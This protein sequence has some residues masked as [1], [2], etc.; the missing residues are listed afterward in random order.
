MKTNNFRSTLRALAIIFTLFAGNLNA[1]IIEINAADFAFTPAIVENAIVGDTVRWTR[2]SGS[3]TTTC[4]GQQ[5]TSRPAGA[6][7]WS[8]PLN[9]ATPIFTYI[10]QIAGTY[11]YICIPHAPSMAGMIIATTSGITQVNEFVNSY[12]LSQNYPNP[13]NPATKI[14]FSIPAS[15]HVTLKVYNNVG[16]EISTLVNENLNSASYEVDWNASELN[17]GVY[18]YKISASDFTE[19]KKMILLK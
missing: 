7:P 14:K 6:A 5:F 13:F 3:H 9:S 8:S 12:Q 11:Q 1:R 19:V 4:D 2:T 18:Y 10:I 15:S 16:Q 17:S